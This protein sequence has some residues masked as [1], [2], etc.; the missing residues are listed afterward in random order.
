MICPHIRASANRSFQPS[1]NVVIAKTVCRR[2]AVRDGAVRYSKRKYYR[3]KHSA[4][5]MAYI[6]VRKENKHYY[7]DKKIPVIV[8]H[9]PP[10][11]TFYYNMR[12]YVAKFQEFFRKKQFIM[13]LWKTR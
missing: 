1:S 6:P 2:R 4:F 10:L 13:G 3:Q 11:L 5:A 12:A 7:K 8:K 9:I